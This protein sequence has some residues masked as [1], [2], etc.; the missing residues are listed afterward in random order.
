MEEG[1]NYLEIA[2][3][4]TDAAREAGFFHDA[5]EVIPEICETEKR[6]FMALILE[7][8]RLGKDQ[9]SQDEIYQIFNFVSAASGSAIC[10][11]HTNTEAKFNFADI[12]NSEAAINASETVVMELRRSEVA[13]IMADTFLGIAEKDIAEITADPMLALLEALKWHWRISAHLAIG[14]LEGD[15]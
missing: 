8:K 13:R 3:V 9:L 6:F 4:M 10:C 5:L 11:W 12:F 2:R 1:T 14:A 15:E 7:L